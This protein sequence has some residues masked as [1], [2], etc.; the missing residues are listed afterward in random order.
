MSFSAVSSIAAGNAPAR[1]TGH[2]NRRRGP[3]AHG[4]EQRHAR[5]GLAGDG[6]LQI[7]GAAC[8]L[9]PRLQNLRQGRETARAARLGGIL[10]RLR[11]RE[12][13][14]RHVDP[15]AH[16]IQR[17]VGTRDVEDDSLV[18]GVEAEVGRGERLPVRVER[19]FLAAEI[20]QQPLERQ[21]RQEELRVGDEESFGLEGGGQRR[22]N[23][24]H[25]PRPAFAESTGA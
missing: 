4:F 24:L 13:G 5:I 15:P 10:Q 20:E 21:G 18:R 14:A 22:R 3:H 7:V 2:G 11:K 1:K 23:V 8:A 9:F 19:R 12:R 17:I 25:P 16:G 6:F